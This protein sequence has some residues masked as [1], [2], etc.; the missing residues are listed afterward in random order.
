METYS[1][2]EIKS[3][4][5]NK[6]FFS[7]IWKPKEEKK[8][9]PK[10]D[11]DI[12]DLEK[13]ENLEKEIKGLNENSN[14]FKKIKSLDILNNDNEIDEIQFLTKKVESLFESEMDNSV[15]EEN[16]K[17]RNS[18][19][20]LDT[21]EPIEKSKPI[22]SNS[23]DKTK[24]NYSADDLIKETE[25]NNKKS[26]DE[27][28]KDNNPKKSRLTLLINNSCPELK[29]NGLTPA[30]FAE[31]LYNLEESEYEGNPVSL[32][33]TETDQYHQETLK[34]YMNNFEFNNVEIDEA[35]RILCKKLVITG[36]TQQIDR[37]LTQFSKHYFENNTHRHDLFL[38]EDV[39]HSIVYSLVLL[40]TDLHIVYNDN[41][42]K[43]MTKKEFLKNTMTLLESMTNEPFSSQSKINS[44]NIPNSNR[45][46]YFGTPNTTSPKPSVSKTLPRNFVIENR[47]VKQKKWKKQMEQLLSD[48]YNSIKNKRILQKVA[49]QENESSSTQSLDV[50]V[51]SSTDTANTNKIQTLFGSEKSSSSP[52]SS[53]KNLISKSTSRKIK[54]KNSNNLNLDSTS[55]NSFND[56]SFNNNN[57]K[58]NFVIVQKGA[59]NRKHY[60]EQG[61][62]RAKD[63]RWAKAH[64]ALCIDQSG[65]SNGVCELRIWIDSASSKKKNSA[66]KEI[67]D[68][69]EIAASEP[70][71]EIQNLPY[72][73]TNYQE[74][75]PITHSVTNIIKSYTSFSALRKNV[76]SLKLSSGSTYLFEAANED[77]MKEWVNALNFWA[78][79]KSK[80][81]LRGAVGNMEYGWNQVEKIEKLKVPTEE[82][83]HE[84]IPIY[85]VFDSS[86]DAESIKSYTSSSNRDA[87]SKANSIRSGLSS[88]NNK[89][90]GIKEINF[91]SL[92]DSQ[93]IKE[94]RPTRSFTISRFRSSSRSSSRNAELRSTARSISLSRDDNSST[95]SGKL[96]SSTTRSYSCT[97][98]SQ[99][100]ST[101]L[102][103][104]NDLNVPSSTSSVND[105]RSI[106]DMQVSPL[107]KEPITIEIDNENENT[108]NKN[109]DN[110]NSEKKIT[111]EN[112]ENQENKDSQEE[113]KKEKLIVDKTETGTGTGTEAE[114]EAETE[115][116]N[117]IKDHNLL[118]RRILSE[119]Q[120]RTKIELDRNKTKKRSQ[121][122]NHFTDGVEI[123]RSEGNVITISPIGLGISSSATPSITSELIKSK[124]GQASISEEEHP[125]SPFVLPRSRTLK[126]RITS[127]HQSLMPN[128][129]RYSMQPIT[130]TTS[131]TT[132]SSSTINKKKIKKL[133]IN[134]WTQPGVGF[135]LS[136][137]SLEK[138]FESMKR[139]YIIIEKELEEH[140]EIKQPMEDLYVFQS[141]A[142][143]K[144]YNNWNKKYMYLLGE[145]NKYGLYVNILENHIKEDPNEDHLFP[146]TSTTTLSLA[147]SQISSISSLEPSTNKKSTLGEDLTSLSEKEK[148]NEKEKITTTTTTQDVI[149][150]ILAKKR[151]QQLDIMKKTASDLSID[152]GNL[153]KSSFI[154]PEINVGKSL[155]EDD[156]YEKEL[157][158]LALEQE[159]LLNLNKD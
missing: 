49:Q 7:K 83:I 40:N 35:L 77:M 85:D 118:H 108:K 130:N 29:K 155:F 82:E 39:T 21:E 109:S 96:G 47:E 156:E 84:P 65:S 87:T 99:G 101:H 2:E 4:K 104:D 89:N 147:S 124:L 36:E 12:V 60:M 31:K 61:K 153:E 129:Q 149:K 112:Q 20:L 143:Q 19:Y 57:E 157:E 3:K 18:E 146:P 103:S 122:L 111:T 68:V 128:S 140:K 98:P 63:R 38:N 136:T 126:P 23:N 67:V 116:E 48:L 30:E 10:I 78:A 135:L 88:T 90:D 44:A 94:E 107:T 1:S 32:I 22:E 132:S 72:Y 14:D 54:D 105:T 42:N 95:F 17:I 123:T 73:S 80:E 50:P 113:M 154:L 134:D 69:F 45:R 59:L 119:P 52:F 86:F 115:T 34:H 56:R 46:S 76:F 141:S 71:I 27:N 6:G 11:N 8:K 25:K 110:D 62:Q 138:Q 24:P 150:S 145:K 151:Q 13:D 139:Q 26:E 66:N 9:H 144:A 74:V 33:L 148:E 137:L 114:T 92:Q 53:M 64:C 133:R 55:Y 125:R 58:G 117:K 28:D 51:S 37:I 75:L 70:D 16:D 102:G 120:L 81:P 131:S 97:R 142:Y 41:P 91:S 79:R 121:S 15:T 152:S 158:E 43:K 100:H 159:R 5:S 93:S 106:N 127:K